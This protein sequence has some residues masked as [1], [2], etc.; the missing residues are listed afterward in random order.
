MGSMSLC[1]VSQTRT[2]PRVRSQDPTIKGGMAR[3][4]SCVGNCDNLFL[5]PELDTP[6]NNVIKV[7][8]V[9]LTHQDV[10][11]NVVEQL[12]RTDLHNRLHLVDFGNTLQVPLLNDKTH[13]V[14]SARQAGWI[15]MGCLCDCFNE[16]LGILFVLR[17]KDDIH[18]VR[19]GRQHCHGRWRDC[20][21]IWLQSRRNHKVRR[22]NISPF[23]EIELANRFQVRWLV[24]T[25][26]SVV[27]NKLLDTNFK[28]LELVLI[29]LGHRSLC[30]DQNVV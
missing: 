8:N 9:P 23:D 27:G 15:N 19:M 11:S 30:L 22:V 12:V 16:C 3:V 18:R 29:V 7:S 10:S 20:G 13:F 28:A 4:E 24:S 26:V 25:E 5:A 1:I 17:M 14:F 2:P 21:T 6:N